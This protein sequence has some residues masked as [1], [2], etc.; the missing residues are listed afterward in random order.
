MVDIP[1]KPHLL[2]IQQVSI[3]IQV[4][5]NTVRNYLAEGKLKGHNP[6]GNT[7][8]LRITVESVRSYLQAFLIDSFDEKTFDE[9][10]Q[11]VSS[12]KPAPIRPVRKSTGWV[13][14]W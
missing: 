1:I 9:Q 3:I 6:N 10:I 13:R 7:K 2:T 5:P 11:H 4:H 8:G 14:Q 12:H